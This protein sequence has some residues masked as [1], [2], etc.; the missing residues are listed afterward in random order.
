MI[1]VHLNDDEK[2]MLDGEQGRVRQVCMEYLVEMCRIAGAERLVD[3]DGTGDMHTPGLKMSDFYEITL[4]DL[5][6]LVSE[7]GRFRIPTFA[8]KSPFPEQPPIHG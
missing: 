2:R 5:R 4:D 7:G 1:T 3:L 8:N 6:E